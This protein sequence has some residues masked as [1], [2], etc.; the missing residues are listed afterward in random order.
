MKEYTPKKIKALVKKKGSSLAKLAKRAGFHPTEV[1][2]CLY[3]P[4][5][6]GE[7]IIA[8]FLNIHPMKIWPE[9]YDEKG[10]PLHPYASAKQ[11]KPFSPTCKEKT[12]QE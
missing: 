1:Q 12:T 9:R 6:F 2:G 7:Q 11:L 4:I 5:F 10:N 3:T 8:K